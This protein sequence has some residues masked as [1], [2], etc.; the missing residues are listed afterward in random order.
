MVF[1]RCRYQIYNHMLGLPK[2]RPSIEDVI[3][4]EQPQTQYAYQV[5]SRR[6]DAI[7]DKNMKDQSTSCH[8]YQLRLFASLLDPSTTSLIAIIFPLHPTGSL[9]DSSNASV[10]M[11]DL[12][13]KVQVLGLTLS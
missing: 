6:R 12:V 13:Y 3:L 5:H 7:I 11:V 4:L 1:V 2:E 9:R 10:L 8:V